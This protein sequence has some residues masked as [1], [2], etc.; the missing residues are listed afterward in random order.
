VTVDDVPY[1]C[2]VDAGALV[3]E[4]VAHPGDLP[5]GDRVIVRAGIGAE[6]LHRLAANLDVA[7]HGVLT[8]AIGEERVAVV[9]GVIEHGVDRVPRMREVRAL[10]VYRATASERICSRRY[11]QV[12]DL[13]RED[14]PMA[15]EVDRVPPPAKATSRGAGPFANPSPDIAGSLDARSIPARCSSGR[16]GLDCRGHAAA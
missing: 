2:E 4:L 15:E 12:D 3:D 8:L 16:R 7:D 6:A 1:E 14:Q 5:P 13:E 11:V 10:A 9:V